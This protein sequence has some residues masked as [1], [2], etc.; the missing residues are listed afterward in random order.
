[1]S[2]IKEEDQ[3]SVMM[4]EAGVRDSERLVEAKMTIA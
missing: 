4:S 3:G 2:K 1:M